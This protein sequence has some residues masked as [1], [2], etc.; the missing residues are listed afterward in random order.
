MLS[1][2]PPD[3]PLA[4]IAAS[5]DSDSDTLLDPTNVPQ[6]P[7]KRRTLD[8]D[9]DDGESPQTT[10]RMRNV[11]NEGSYGSRT[12]IGHLRRNKINRPLNRNLLSPLKIS[13]TVDDIPDDDEDAAPTASA[14]REAQ[15]FGCLSDDNHYAT[16]KENHFPR[17]QNNLEELTDDLVTLLL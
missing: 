9:N 11:L 2:A 16:L 15:I 12:A 14:L 4:D 3:S 8:P 7:R 5:D 1:P 17:L 10:P 6:P 13:V